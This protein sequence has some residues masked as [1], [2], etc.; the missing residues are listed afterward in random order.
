MI[1]RILPRSILLTTALTV[2][3]SGL[4]GTASAAHDDMDAVSLAKLLVGKE[5][6]AG[7]ATP[8][9][10]FDSPGF[11]HYIFD[12]LNY[13]LP[14]TLDAQYNMNKTKITKIS[15]LEEGDVVFFGTG[16][17]PSFAGVFIG[18]GKFVSSSQSQDEVVTR[19]MSSYQDQFIGARRILSKDDRV[20]IQLVLTARKY[21][22][23]PYDFGAKYGQT[24]TFDCSSFVKTVFAKYG[25]TLPRVSKN[26]AK[27]GKYVKKADLKVG[28]LVFFT[29]E[30]TGK[31]IGHVG[32]YVGN[33]QMI[34]TY[35]EGGVKYESIHKEWWADHYVTARRIVD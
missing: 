1:K 17:N 19:S 34:H 33:G 4:A 15:S 25:Y 13:D 28:D 22:G 16:Q 24:K 9:K 31:Q 8:G 3:L 35:G 32:M 29:T 7:A 21:L 18:G 14:R 26:Q 27:E 6:T 2:G 12:Q 23:T 11:I 20:R 10:G 5:Y 30:R